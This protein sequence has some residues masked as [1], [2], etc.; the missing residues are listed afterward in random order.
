MK[1]LYQLILAAIALFP[2]YKQQLASRDETITVLNGKVAKLEADAAT[3][4]AA[5]NAAEQR[6]SDAEARR[7]A[8]AKELDQLHS[9]AD[10]LAV[11]MLDHPD[12][13][14]PTGTGDQGGQNP[15]PIAVVPDPVSE[16]A[17][18]DPPPAQS[19][20]VPPGNS[21]TAS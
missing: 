6:A 2:Q 8:D 7:Q 12:A 13:Q 20:P 18:V 5:R 15:P 10:D 4:V 21:E 1:S 19:D 16:P 17:P 9:T 11:A 3:D 14:P